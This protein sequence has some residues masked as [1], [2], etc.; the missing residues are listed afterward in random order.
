MMS[1]CKDC[2]ER[3]FNCHSGCKAYEEY[4]NKVDELNAKKH[5]RYGNGVIHNRTWRKN[6]GREK[7]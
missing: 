4:K 2:I 1:P 7:G 5:E 3:R 6:H